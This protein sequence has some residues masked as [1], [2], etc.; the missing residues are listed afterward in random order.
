MR[1]FLSIFTLIFFTPFLFVFVVVVIFFVFALQV[2]GRRVRVEAAHICYRWWSRLVVAATLSRVRVH[3]RENIPTGQRYT[4]YANHS[5]FIDIP[6]LSGY[7]VPD[8]A[9]AARKSLIYSPI[10]FWVLA[11]DGVLIERKASRKELKKVLEIVDK[12]KSGRPFI[13]FPEGT[14]THTDR[15]GKLKP[16]SIKIAQKA[17]AQIVPVRIKG[18]LEILPRGAFWPKPGEIELSVGKPIS[19]EKID[20]NQEEVLKRL[21]NYL[22]VG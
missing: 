4:I 14:R 18:T 17:R 21:E 13:I 6:V 10:G 16:G 12:I 3:G 20:E 19:P 2:L 8:A 11:G 15:L 1:R 22:S 9:Y 5:S 7:L